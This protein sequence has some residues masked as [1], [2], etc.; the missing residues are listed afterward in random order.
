MNAKEFIRAESLKG[1]HEAP[2]LTAQD[3]GTASRAL[4]YQVSQLISSHGKPSITKDACQIYIDY[5]NGKY[6]D[7]SKPIPRLILNQR[8]ADNGTLSKIY[9]K[10]FFRYKINS[11]LCG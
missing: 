3:S 11:D 4:F 2:A 8:T 1:A 5:L 6:I 9:F 10:G 7:K